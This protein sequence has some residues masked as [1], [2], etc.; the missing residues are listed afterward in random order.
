LSD[1]GAARIATAVVVDKRRPTASLRAD[2]AC[3][4]G[5]DDFIVGYGMDDAGFGRGLPYIATVD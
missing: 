1:A 4:V 3:F 2:H 5:V